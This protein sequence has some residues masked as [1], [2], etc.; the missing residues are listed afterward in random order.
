M[1]YSQT[2]YIAT[3]NG[4]TSIICFFKDAKSALTANDISPALQHYTSG[5]TCMNIGRHSSTHAVLTMGTNTC[6][7]LASLEGKKAIQVSI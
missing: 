4:V 5:S 7:V 2:R 6:I 1:F 3:N